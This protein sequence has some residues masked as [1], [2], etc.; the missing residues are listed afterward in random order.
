M[1]KLITSFQAVVRGYMQRRQVRK[2]LYR[3]EAL[4]VLQENLIAFG[5]LQNDP[6][7]QLYTR[8]KPLVSTARAAQEE[9]AK[10]AA[11][12][13]MVAKIEAEVRPFSS[14]DLTSEKTCPAT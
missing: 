5:N 9:E 14:S 10:R 12:A 8:M 13:A 6:W 2:K 7:W 1:Q 11:V 3:H 4:G